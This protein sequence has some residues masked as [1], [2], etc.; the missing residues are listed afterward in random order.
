MILSDDLNSR[1]GSGPTM[2]YQVVN[3]ATGQLESEFPAATDAEI[4]ELLDRAGSTAKL[5]NELSVAEFVG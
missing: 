3:P 4:S 1:H 5:A 2:K